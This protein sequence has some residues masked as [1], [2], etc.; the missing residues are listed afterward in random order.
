MV[1]LA[2]PKGYSRYQYNGITE[3]SKLS[4]MLARLAS[5]V[6]PG[7]ICRP[8]TLASL[9]LRVQR[10]MSTTADV[11]AFD[12]YSRTVIDVVDK[13]GDSVVAINVP[14]TQSGSSDSAGSGVILSP[15][16]YVLTN[17]HVVGDAAT[18][19]V[20]LTDGRA[21]QADVK[22]RDVA[23]DLALLRVLSNGLPF[24]SLMPS[25]LRVGQLV[26]AIG[27][28][29]GCVTT[30]LDIAD[31]PVPSQAC[32]P[33]SPKVTLVFDPV[34]QLPVHGECRCGICSR[35]KHARK[36][37]ADDRG[38]NAMH[39]TSKS[40]LPSMCLHYCMDATLLSE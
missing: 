32:F 17:A 31:L 34:F 20:S 2:K 19:S 9:G 27:N 40:P 23:T 5:A 29:L 13:V 3:E 37:W 7:P 10:S 33:P 21:L 14:A 6:R 4:T 1:M 15:D 36:G 12:A 18:V 38:A 8:K 11:A 26:V 16:G 24:A 39:H 35:S 28:P 30:S 25:Q 22:G